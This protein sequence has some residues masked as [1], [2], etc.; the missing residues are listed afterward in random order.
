MRQQGRFSTKQQAMNMRKHSW[1][2]L[3]CPATFGEKHT[4]CPE[5]HNPVQYFP[6]A[7]ELKRYRELQLQQRA[8]MISGLELQPPYDVVINGEKVFT[9]RADFRYTRDGQRVIEDVKGTTNE[10]YLDDTFKL[11]RKIV[12]AIFGIRVTIVK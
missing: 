8:G 10:K 3:K 6:S 4:A 12:E 7:N 5:C 9:Y 11:K 2:C 1:A